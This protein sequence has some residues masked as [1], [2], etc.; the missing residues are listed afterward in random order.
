MTMYRVLQDE[1]RLQP[2]RSLDFSSHYQERNLEDWLEKNPL[3]QN[4]SLWTIHYPPVDAHT[5]RIADVLI[6]NILMKLE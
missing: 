2:F 1:H 5:R 4:K 3:R 6:E